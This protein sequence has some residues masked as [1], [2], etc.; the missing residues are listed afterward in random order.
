MGVQ[1]GA[2]YYSPEIGKKPLN[3]GGYSVKEEVSI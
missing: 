3:R 1:N 2:P